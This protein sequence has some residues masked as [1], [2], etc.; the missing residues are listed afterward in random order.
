MLAADQPGQQHDRNEPRHLVLLE[1]AAHV[2]AARAGQLH[3]EQHHVGHQS[4]HRIDHA[5]AVVHDVDGKASSRQQAR[6]R[7]GERRRVVDDEHAAIAV[8]AFHGFSAASHGASGFP[9]TR[10]DSC[11]AAWPR[12]APRRRVGRDLGR[13]A[14]RV[15]RQAAT[16]GGHG[17]RP[18]FAAGIG[19]GDAR[20][21]AGDAVFGLPG[22]EVSGEHGELVAAHAGHQVV[23][24][25][26]LQQH[27]GH[28]AQHL[29]ARLVPERVGSVAASPF[30]TDR[31]RS[32]EATR[33]VRLR[34]V[35][36]QARRRLA[37]ICFRASTSAISRALI[38]CGL[39]RRPMASKR[40]VDLVMLVCI[41]DIS[42]PMVDT[43]SRSAATTLIDKLN[44][45]GGDE[46]V[47]QPSSV[48]SA[49]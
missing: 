36:S 27:L 35:S 39:L 48:G 10:P 14:R 12:S 22:G 21:H 20:Q 7:V 31:S 2:E 24:A 16:E 42:E 38:C 43:T 18:L 15:L 19:R 5:L 9:W 3:V 46:A 13:V 1:A 11:P 28:V 8:V 33:W 49:A 26:R 47:S 4:R 37:A 45:L 17:D 30:T 29:V 34:A 25:E 23:G 41:V 40:S 44:R 32:S 6:Q